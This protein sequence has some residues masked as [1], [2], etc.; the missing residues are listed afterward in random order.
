MEKYLLPTNLKIHE[1]V[2]LLEIFQQLNTVS[3]VELYSTEK[4]PLFAEGKIPCFSQSSLGVLIFQ[5]A[6]TFSVK[7]DQEKIDS[8]EIYREAWYG[9]TLQGLLEQSLWEPPRVTIRTPLKITEPYVVFAPFGFNEETTI[10]S[11]LWIDLILLAR[12][13]NLRV[14]LLGDTAER[15][16]TA[17]FAENDIFSDDPIETKLNILAGASVVIGVPNAWLWLA[18]GMNKNLVYLYDVNWPVKKWFW[19]QA[20]NF[21]RLMVDKTAIRPTIQ[22][23]Q[24]K[25][26]FNGVFTSSY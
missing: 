10:A 7:P 6:P 19:H 22:L 23:A 2:V 26:W 11:P 20:L 5:L 14:V 12:S 17:G 16:D 8:V 13:Y 1:Q 24:M 15:I 4:Y 3:P 25:T 18:A 9:W 21:G